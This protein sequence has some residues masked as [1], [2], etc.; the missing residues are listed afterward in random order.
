MDSNVRRKMGKNVYRY[1]MWLLLIS[2]GGVALFSALLKGPGASIVASV[3]GYEVSKRELDERMH[4]LNQQIQDIRGR[5]GTQANFV[6]MQLGL[7]GDSKNVALNQLMGRALLTSG[8]ESLGFYA[9]SKDY[10]SR[11]IGDRLF[12]QSYLG[13]IVPVYLLSQTGIDWAALAHYLRGAQ[14]SKE[15]FDAQLQDAFKR[16]FVRMLLPTTVYVPLASVQKEE[17][18]LRGKRDFVVISADLTA[19]REQIRQAGVK[20]EEI[21]SFFEQEN[22]RTQRYWKEESRAG[23]VWAFP[24]KT[25]VEV[26]E[27]DV[28]RAFNDQREKLDKMTLEQARP[29]LIEELKR[30][31][32]QRHFTM[33]SKEVSSDTPEAKK[34]FEELVK[35]YGATSH[36]VAMKPESESDKAIYRALYTIPAVGQRTALIAGNMGYVVL[37]EKL[38]PRACPSLTD[39]REKVVEDICTN[40]ARVALEQ[41]LEKLL[42]ASKKD[43]G[44]DAK[45]ASGLRKVEYKGVVVG[46]ETWKQ[47]KHL[48]LERMRLMVHPGYGLVHMNDKG[49]EVVI[50]KSI[51]LP[52]GEATPEQKKEIAARAGRLY[53]EMSEMLFASF[54]EH[55]HK[56]ATIKTYQ[57]GDRRALPMPD[58][59]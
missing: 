5:F 22:Q 17:L 6:L 24:L 34:L 3:N 55:L 48:P 44:F 15:A 25:D 38:E 58:D 45:L 30:T 8:A 13:D 21:G 49:G 10:I 47:F 51:S 56:E 4:A 12:V 36:A 43:S 14:I 2:L 29:K 59:F 7:A 20:A 53:G 57:A 18:A 52:T 39:V 26:S 28:I 1:I 35:K 32:A 31:A 19:Y 40:R 41:D 16:A 42:E 9:V 46:D 54:G 50:L 33:E 27:A 37:L 11:K 23:T